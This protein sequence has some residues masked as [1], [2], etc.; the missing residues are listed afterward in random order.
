MSKN[1]PTTDQQDLNEPG[2]IPFELEQET[3]EKHQSEIE[4]ITAEKNILEDR[5]R[6]IEA[7]VE[8]AEFAGNNKNKQRMWDEQNAKDD[9]IRYAYLPSLDGKDPIVEWSAV[10]GA[11]SYVDANGYVRDE[12]SWVIKTRDGIEKRVALEEVGSLI[13]GNGIPCRVNNWKAYINEVYAIDELK[14]Q[15]QRSTNRMSAFDL[16]GLLDEIESRSTKLSVNVTLS[17]DLGKSYHGDTLD[18]P[19]RLLNGHR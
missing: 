16:K 2:D 3:P 15:Y 7:R 4:R 17:N 11:K 8:R 1:K 12:Q 19:A 9:N 5:L 14:Q 13:S 6:K 10:K 18:V